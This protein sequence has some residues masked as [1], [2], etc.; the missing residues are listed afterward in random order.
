LISFN[1]SSLDLDAVFGEEGMLAQTYPHYELRKEQIEMAKGVQKAFAKGKHLAVEAGT[2]TGKSFAYLVCAIDQALRTNTK[3]IIS[4]H[5][6]NLQEQ[7]INKDIPFLANALDYD[8]TATLAKGRSN[9]VCLRRLQYATKMGKTLFDDVVSEIFE[10][11]EWAADT[12]NGSLS[13]MKYAPSM[14]AWDAVH[15]EHGNCKGRKCEMYKECHYWRARRR[16]EMSDV[17]VVNHALL[18]SDLALKEHSV[19]VL[20]DYGCIV[21][22]EA[23]NIENVAEDHFGINISNFSINYLLNGLHKTKGNKGLLAHTDCSEGIELVRE[24]RESAKI[25]F[26]QVQS[27]YDNSYRENNGRCQRGFVD[28]NLSE[29][30]NS[31]RLAVKR[32]VNSLDDDDDSKLEFTRSIDRLKSLEQELK[33]FINQPPNDI[34]QVFWVESSQSRLRRITLRNAPI[35]VGPDIK[36]CLFDAFPSV[37][38]TSATLSCGAG[39]KEDFDFFSSRIGLEDYDSLMLGSP[40][41]YKNQVTLHIEASLPEPNS[42]D[43]T[44][45]AIEVVKRYLSH[46]KGKAFVLFTSYAMLRN[47]A[48]N[49][50]DWFE[51]NE[52]QLLKQGDGLDR[53]SLL[54]E[55]KEDTHS[56]LFGTSSFWQGVDVPGE[57]LSN[58]IIVRLPFAVPNHPLIQG[59]IEKLRASGEMPFFKYQLPSAII[60]FKQG[61]GRLVRKKTDK[62]IVVVLDSRIVTKSY[63]RKFIESIPPCNIEIAR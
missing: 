35:D 30:I 34:E 19:G 48:E 14:A 33:I 46:T 41:D 23:H 17:I 45:A 32:H 13:D 11:N 36:R 58:V 6:I 26:A 42:P 55:F 54:E 29:S 28:D 49:L 61:F 50:E 3:A 37:I 24:C 5:T 20:P 51:E 57:S 38:T 22:D 47:F 52:I 27:W 1:S 39:A 21:L 62:G 44:P 15:S 2:G 31:L 16:L 60:K 12:S 63:G 56:V 43:F 25:F 10:I 59:R 4:T 8:F 7:L 9:Y 53:S 40:F 18:F